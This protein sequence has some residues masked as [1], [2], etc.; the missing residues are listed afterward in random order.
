MKTLAIRME[1]EQHARLSIMSRLADVS[2]TETIRQ[3]IEAR[4][5]AMA[6]DP[7]LSARAEALVAEIVRE[8]EEQRQALAG[9]FPA[10]GAGR[11]GRTTK[12]T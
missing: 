10:H 6:S 3:A 12:T 7:D 8:A 5:D 11:T 4:L 9:L 1:E 2:I